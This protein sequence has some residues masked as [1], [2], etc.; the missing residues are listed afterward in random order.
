MGGDVVYGYVIFFYLV[1]TDILRFKS[2]V[3]LQ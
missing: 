2:R 3:N 1:L